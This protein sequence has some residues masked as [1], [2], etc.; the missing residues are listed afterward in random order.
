MIRAALWTAALAVS[1]A[2]MAQAPVGG[3]LLGLTDAELQ[4]VLPEVQRLHKPVTGPRGL[5]GVWE[6]ADTR[7]H[8]LPFTST[9]YL[10]DK[11]VQRVEQLWNAHTTQC[12]A[13]PAFGAIA[14]DLDAQYG[15]GMAA[16]EEQD[17]QQSSVWLAGDFD[18]VAY[19]TRT[20][21][22]CSIRL[23]YQW[24]QTR[25]ASEL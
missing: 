16:G 23:V 22:A 6:I 2:S 1:G 19:F 13:E 5:R 3:H 15:A 18:V 10:R 7:L 17:A 4:T 25:D 11:R 12:T 9:F 20:P 21:V 24:H 8:G 14:A